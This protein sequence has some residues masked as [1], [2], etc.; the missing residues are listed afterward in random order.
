MA[1]TKAHKAAKG[2]AAG[3]G[4]KTEVPL[5]GGG[6]LDA[7]TKGG[8]TATEIER[9]GDPDKLQRAA[10]RLQKSG[11]PKK[12]LQVPQ[13]DMRKASEAMRKSKVGGTVKNMSGTKRTSVSKPKK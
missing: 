4:G 5:P 3:R 2:K 8:G 11:A 6:R 9:S 10:R 12:V 1:E 13:K 7:K